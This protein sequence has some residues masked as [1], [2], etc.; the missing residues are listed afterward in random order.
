MDIIARLSNAFLDNQLNDTLNTELMAEMEIEYIG[1]W[2]NGRPR[3]HIN[4]S[5]GNIVVH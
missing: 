1:K 2:N 3:R 5:P 4:G